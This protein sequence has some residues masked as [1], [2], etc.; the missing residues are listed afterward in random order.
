VNRPEHYCTCGHVERH[1]KQAAV[2]LP[3]QVCIWKGCPCADFEDS[4]RTYRVPRAV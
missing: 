1:H 3:V 4:D 2:W